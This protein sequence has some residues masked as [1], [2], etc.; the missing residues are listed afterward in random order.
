M[1]PPSNT[2]ARR[3][4]VLASIAMQNMKEIHCSNSEIN[5]KTLKF[6]YL[7][8]KVSKGVSAPLDFQPTLKAQSPLYSKIFPDT[9][10]PANPW[11]IFLKPD[12]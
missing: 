10:S 4:T 5:E 2:A 3:C 6:G 12:T 11:I 7:I 9:L 1:D 8:L